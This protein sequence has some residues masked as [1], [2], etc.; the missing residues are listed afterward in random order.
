[1]WTA[2]P[3]RKRNAVDMGGDTFAP[4]PSQAKRCG[5]VS[6]KQK[7]VEDW[8]EMYL[9]LAAFKE[10]EGHCLPPRKYDAD[11][12]LPAWVELQRSIWNRQ[13]RVHGDVGSISAPGGRALVP[14]PILP[15]APSGN[16][17]PEQAPGA[18]DV[19]GD[20]SAMVARVA[21]SNSS[22]LLLMTEKKLSPEQKAKLD[23]LGFVW[24]LRSRRVDEHWEN[25]FQQLVAY[26][27]THGHAQVPSRWEANIKLS[28]WVET[29]RYEFTKLHR[30]ANET[31]EGNEC[32]AKPR[33]SNANPNPRLTEDRIR[34]LESIGFEWRVKQKTK[35]Y[36]DKQWDEMFQ[37]LLLYREQHH[38]NTLIPKRYPPDPRLGT[39]AATQRVQYKK[40]MEGRPK[41]GD[42]ISSDSGDDP[43]RGLSDEEM[44]FRLT[45]DRRRRLDDIGFVWNVRESDK[46][47]EQGCHATLHDN[48]WD[49]KLVGLLVSSWV[50]FLNLGFVS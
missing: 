22:P 43:Q 4:A 42:A 20:G 6:G 50:F 5:S 40:L 39:W 37:R 35:R 18:P 24:S 33:A 46:S 7:G 17:V 21:R 14:E 38:G 1:M 19:M 27:E 8:N 26:K 36:F 28:K 48:H 13:N 9:R 23:A 11:P 16:H 12:R 31:T 34:R 29:Q 47:V 41:Q 44:S 32:N 15:T 30:S 25:M 3:A 10:Q 49:G 2:K 45:D